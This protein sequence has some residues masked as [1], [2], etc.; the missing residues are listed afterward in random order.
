MWTIRLGAT[1]VLAALL[2]GLT[3]APTAAQQRPAGAAV[4]P[5]QLEVRGLRRRAESLR[6]E[7]KRQQRGVGEAR[8]RIEALEARIGSQ[9]DEVQRLRDA[10][11]RLRIWLWGLGI[12]AALALLAAVQ[13]RPGGGGLPAPLAAA[14]ARTSR[15]HEELE[16]LE[17]RVRAA[18]HRSE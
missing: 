13:R 16:A 9:S 5:L 14:R 15:L 17:T 10:G 1:L 6:S 12:L 8:R 2:C 4:S 11:E 18:E 3:V 7:L